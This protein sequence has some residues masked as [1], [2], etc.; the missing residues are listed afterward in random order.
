MGDNG[1]L[2]KQ[3]EKVCKCKH[4]WKFQIEKDGYRK[5]WC[6]KCNATKKEYK[7]NGEKH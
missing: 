6:P 7:D 5:Y 3:F 2:L 4:E 1:V